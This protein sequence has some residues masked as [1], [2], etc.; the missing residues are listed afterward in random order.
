MSYKHFMFIC[1]I[2]NGLSHVGIKVT[3]EIGLG[4]FVP[5]VLFS[6]YLVAAIPAFIHM[7]AERV[8]LQQRSLWVGVL[9][10]LGSTIGMS[11]LMRASGMIPGYIIFPITSGGSLLL[12]V[13]IGSIIFKEKIGL[14]GILGIIV[15]AVAIALLSV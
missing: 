9:A 6:M 2:L 4:R 13:A 10:G 15:G 1:F 7:A 5:L 14:Y 12:V 3:S 8:P 11:S